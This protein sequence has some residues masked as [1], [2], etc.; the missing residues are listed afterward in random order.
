MN[1]HLPTSAP[2]TRLSWIGLVS[3]LLLTAGEVD[4]QQT[5]LD[6]LLAIVPKTVEEHNLKTA[7]KI[8]LLVPQVESWLVEQNG[9]DANVSNK[10]IL[11][12]VVRVLKI[13]QVLNQTLDELYAQRANFRQPEKM[14]D[15]QLA[16]RGF[17]EC[18][19]AL[20]N[21][22][23]KIRYYSVDFFTEAGYELEE[24]PQDYEMLIDSFMEYQNSVGAITSLELIAESV[25]DSENG[26]FSDHIKGKVL[27]LAR[28]T[29]ES[30][31]L[32][33]L[34]EILSEENIDP[35]LVILIVD[36]IRLIGL[37][38]FPRPK[39]D[40]A[41]SPAVVNGKDI[42]EI[43]SNIDL[44]NLSST[45]SLRLQ[46]LMDWVTKHN[47]R[48]EM[49]EEFHFGRATVREGDWLLM[50]NPSPYNRFTDLYPGLFTHAGVITTEIAED[51]KRRF[52]VVDL[53]EIGNTIPATPVEKFVERT[54]D[55]VI[56][57]HHSPGDQKTMGRVAK[58]IISNESKFD[59]NFRTSKI[60]S[61]KGQSLEGKLIDGYCAGLLLL[62][63]QETGKPLQDFF[64]LREHPAG[65]NTLRNL[66]K[67]DVSMP[68]RFLSPTGPL[69]SSHLNMIYR[70]ETMYS[71]RREIEQAIYDHFAEQ[72]RDEHLTP[73]LTWYHT[74]R[75]NL[76]Q[77]AETN[78]TLGRALANAAGVNE[79]IDLVAAAKLGAV[80]E[81]L[82]NI[83]KKASNNYQN[84]RRAFRIDALDDIEPGPEGDKIFDQVV[85]RRRR[86]ADLFVRWEAGILT[87]RELRM[88][89]VDYYIDQGCAQLDRRFFYGSD[90]TVGDE[91]DELKP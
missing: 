70:C 34:V 14:S 46:Q 48:G 13:D 17:L 67:L 73:S 16:V 59:L 68:E 44:A 58:E 72:M 31:L 89:L 8:K 32:P 3:A 27:Q 7:Q 41:L 28:I 85:A 88:A 18:V 6:E 77:A 84:V 15:Q 56:L 42:L 5:P 83:A 12:A 71:P 74:L 90:E 52:V 50:K 22:S 86:H 38:Q 49:D 55:F 79:K 20:I 87:P 21:L 33:I 11:D 57:R 64:P 80:V 29:R 1:S 69:F 91:S 81:T 4:A 37:P 43:L 35:E 62:C 65:G 76:A 45:D 82:D 24:S 40:L 10:K 2:L 51:G 23:G 30:Q 19:T 26:T 66:A 78:P 75:L 53:P 47:A 61:L 60:E 25:R 39:S 54:L 63:A 9:L 36:T